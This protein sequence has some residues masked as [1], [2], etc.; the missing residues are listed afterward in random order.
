MATRSERPT[1]PPS[2]DVSEYA[3]DSDARMRARQPEA[4]AASPRIPRSE[5][6]LT[7]RPKLSVAISDEAWARGM[8]GAPVIAISSDELRRLPLDPHGGFLLSQ[9][10]GTID[11]ETV[12]EIS[13]MPRADALRILRH[14]IESG[15]VVLR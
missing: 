3:R 1:S 2:F 12:I 10:D 14:L 9:M 4:Q 5:T 8:T 11:F 7:T 13:P 6:R 15:V